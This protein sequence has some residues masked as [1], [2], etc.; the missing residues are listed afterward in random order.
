[1]GAAD[2][3]A[4][5][6]EAV[7]PD[8]NRSDF[9][10]VVTRR[11]RPPSLRICGRPGRQCRA[12]AGVAGGA[13]ADVTSLDLYGRRLALA[14]AWLDGATRRS[15]IQVVRN[16]ERPRLELVARGAGDAQV[17]S[18]SLGIGLLFYVRGAA[19]CSGSASTYVRRSF[20][21][22]AE[23]ERPVPAVGDIAFEARE[24]WYGRC[25]AMPGAPASVCSDFDPFNPPIPPPPIT[26]RC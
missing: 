13:R 5:E 17:Y 26:T 19:D 21:T 8:L 6:C 23:L 25:A 7:A 16:I 11:G 4:D 15:A 1:V 24:I 18:P 22:G 14:T 20:N 9:A 2:R 3:R 10:A 12:V